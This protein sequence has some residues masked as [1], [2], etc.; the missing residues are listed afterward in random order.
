MKETPENINADT[1][2]GAYEEMKEDRDRWFGL[3]MELRKATIGTIKEIYTT[4]IIDEQGRTE[5]PDAAD[6]ND[7]NYYG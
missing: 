2:R 5:H 4:N 1:W 6:T 7:P 3:A